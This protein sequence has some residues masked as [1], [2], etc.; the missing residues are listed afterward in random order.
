MHTHIPPPLFK[1]HTHVTKT[2]IQWSGFNLL[3]HANSAGMG[4]CFLVLRIHIILQRN[5][6]IRPVPIS[7]WEGYMIQSPQNST[8]R[9]LKTI[10]VL[11][12]YVP[13]RNRLTKPNTLNFLQFLT[14]QLFHTPRENLRHFQFWAL[15]FSPHHLW[16][17][18]PFSSLSWHGGFQRGG[19]PR[20]QLDFTVLPPGVVSRF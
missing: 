9:C 14:K 15:P 17:S 4:H 3:K 6:D 19:T 18:T 7:T 1:H 12:N 5:P 2:H 10:V 13:T 16:R 8:V 20:D 11:M